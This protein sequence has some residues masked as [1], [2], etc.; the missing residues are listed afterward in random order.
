MDSS[1]LAVFL[2]GGGRIAMFFRHN[3]YTIV[4]VYVDNS[5][6]ASAPA[7]L[8][9]AGVGIT[10]FQARQNVISAVLT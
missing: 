4:A 10:L 1:W 9:K 5:G 7:S 3:T 2:W 8:K 6:E